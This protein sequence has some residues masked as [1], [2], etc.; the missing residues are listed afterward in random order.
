MLMFVWLFTIIM[1]I[2]GILL[3]VLAGFFGLTVMAYIGLACE[4]LGFGVQ[5]LAWRCPNCGKFLGR[6]Q[7]FLDPPTHCQW[8]GTRLPLL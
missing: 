4:V 3:I 1:P 5:L 2:A 8:C 6:H 7:S